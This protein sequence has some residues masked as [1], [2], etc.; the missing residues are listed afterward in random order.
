MPLCLS[1]CLCVTFANHCTALELLKQAMAEAELL[2]SAQEEDT[3]DIKLHCTLMNA[4]FQQYGVNVC[5][6]FLVTMFC[7]RVLFCNHVVT[8]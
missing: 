2:T 4:R 1:V 8:R 7:N 6:R 3:D 5:Y